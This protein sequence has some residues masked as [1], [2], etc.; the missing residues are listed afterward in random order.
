MM[1]PTGESDGPD[2]DGQEHSDDA[3]VE[4]GAALH[5]AR[6]AQGLSLRR[7]ARAL[8]MSGHSGLV[9]YERGSRIPPA[10]IVEASERIFGL[11]PG[12]LA[13]LRARALAERADRAAARLLA[14]RRG[15]RPPAA[16]PRPA[17]EP[18]GTASGPTTTS[19]PTPP[20]PPQA[21]AATTT[22]PDNG[23]D[24]PAAPQL[25]PRGTG[26]FTGRSKLLT[27][28]LASVRPDDPDDECWPLIVLS[29]PAG[30]GKTT[31]AVRVAHLTR[32]HFPDGQL[33]VD[34]RGPDGT[35]RS[36][37]WVLAHF[38]RALGF[39]GAAVPEGFE[40]RIAL[41]RTVLAD[42]SVLVV[43]DNAFDEAQVRNLLPTGPRCA[44]VITSRSRLAGLEGARLV[45][46]APFELDEAIE[47]LV[48]VAGTSRERCDL[49]AAI[50]V[51]QAC[52]FLPLAIRLAGSRA[53]TH[54]SLS[55]LARRL[56][57]ERLRLNELA[58][59]DIEVRSSVNLSY[60]LLAPDEQRAF[61]L[62]GLLEAPD[63]P[64]WVTG[65]L[66]DL[67]AAEGAH[68]LGNATDMHLVDLAPATPAQPDP[69]STGGSAG[70]ATDT[71]AAPGGDTRPDQDGGAV[72]AEPRRYRL[73]DLLRLHARETAE[74]E[75]SEQERHDALRRVMTGYLRRAVHAEWRL[76]GGVRGLRPGSVEPAARA[77]PGSGDRAGS[78]PVVG[79][80]AEQSH[81][82]DVAP[83]AARW[84][85]TERSAIV[86][87]ILQASALGWHELAA[88]L[89]CTCGPY[90]AFRR[91]YDDWWHTHEAVL[92][93]CERAG[94]ERS[95][96]YVQ[97]H[98]G[99]LHIIRGR[100]AEGVDI[101]EQTVS[102]FL[103]VGD[104]RGV[105]YSHRGLGV[106]HHGQGRLD[107]AR[108]ELHAALALFEELDDRQGMGWTLFSLG[109][110]EVSAGLAAPAQ[111]HAS[112][113]LD[114]ARALPDDMLRGWLLRIL[115][116]SAREAMRLDEAE[117]LLSESVDLFRRI[118]DHR[119]VSHNLISIGLVH[120][121]ADR[122]ADAEHRL[123]EGLWLAQ[124]LLDRWGEGLAHYHL[125]D[126]C[127][128][129]GRADLARTHL[130]AALLKFRELGAGKWERHAIARIEK[131]ANDSVRQDGHRAV[132]P[133]ARERSTRQ[134]F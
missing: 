56:S 101:Y 14:G 124:R 51:C 129:T 9:D 25:V 127:S 46:V 61:R 44:T 37:P 90:F 79:P 2:P 45:E 122:Y 123:S 18:R 69:V 28:L 72:A 75:E 74:R 39:E 118:A 98:L 102:R 60:E 99:Y 47:L 1:C 130:H 64:A 87:L 97:H 131:L 49:S 27:D 108:R 3:A 103:R 119:A 62:L 105:A 34:L 8:G 104:Q 58:A 91:E 10:D 54:Y 106:A 96:A 85:D 125:G 13:V 114:I 57:D 21:D 32:Q 6:L 116:N 109:A 26:D 117:R 16:T 23:A 133:V 30:V 107:T 115:G 48:R 89:A 22:G 4:L 100:F 31:L 33:Y 55:E 66:T 41:Y 112:R 12:E 42:R 5:R 121:L 86:A 38:L 20:G 120:L 15:G 92:A 111:A 77:E 80:V 128:A 17:A 84:F 7:W 59:G 76:P 40:D 36:P 65:A 68:L 83:D 95:A 63:Y 70:S 81:R 11:A 113:G 24:G 29:G 52:G 67:P 73:H 132:D 94:D 134:G 53:R 78:S 88:D 110:L 71:E 35:R 126:V 82:T 93:A 19:G 43:L 50:E